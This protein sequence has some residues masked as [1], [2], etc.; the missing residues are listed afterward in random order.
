MELLET[1]PNGR[2]I[3]S[4]PKDNI[5]LEKQQA[6][7]L[8]DAW[9]QSG[10]EFKPIFQDNNGQLWEIEGGGNTFKTAKNPEGYRFGNWLKHFK[11]GI[12]RRGIEKQATPN[13]KEV[14]AAVKS[15]FPGLSNA[16]NLKFAKGLINLNEQQMVKTLASRRVGQHTDHMIPLAKGG[17][18]WFKNFANIDAATNLR[19]SAKLL[20]KRDQQRLNISRNRQQMILS[21]LSSDLVKDN[22]KNKFQEN[23]IKNAFKPNSNTSKTLTGYTKP[24]ITKGLNM[25]VQ[26]DAIQT[27]VKFDKKPTVLQIMKEIGTP[28]D[29]VFYSPFGP[30]I[31]KI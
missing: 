31:T 4:R 5:K 6:I 7:K 21:G 13:L 26:A 27:D 14:A 28:H 23:V 2:E 30:P 20:S 15:R 22:P 16:D 8:H 10:K 1:L 11:R 9:K 17:L 12:T 24:T 19:K 18:N 3:F 25:P 29:N